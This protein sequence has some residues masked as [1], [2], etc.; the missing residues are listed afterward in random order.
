MVITPSGFTSLVKESVQSEFL[1]AHDEELTVQGTLDISARACRAAS[2][3]LIPFALSSFV[4]S[5][6]DGINLI[7]ISNKFFY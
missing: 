7:I 4:L 5:I 3:A 6:N 1:V 2:R